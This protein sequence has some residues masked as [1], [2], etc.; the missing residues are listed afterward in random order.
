[1]DDRRT[2]SKVHVVAKLTGIVRCVQHQKG[3]KEHS[4]VSA[5]QILQQLFRFTAVGGKVRGNDV[6]VVS[7]ADCFFLFLDL[8]AIQVGN[9]ALSKTR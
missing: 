1:M 4:L 5:L 3:D 7:C 2:D 9:L 6:H 8:T